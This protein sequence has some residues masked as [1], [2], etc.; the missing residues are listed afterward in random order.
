MV[1]KFPQLQ[2]VPCFLRVHFTRIQG[3]GTDTAEFLLIVDNDEPAYN[4]EL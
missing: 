1:A 2:F 3:S 4:V